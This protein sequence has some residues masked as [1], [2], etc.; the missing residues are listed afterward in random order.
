MCM[1]R[2]MDAVDEHGASGTECFAPECAGI[3]HYNYLKHVPQVYYS[4]D[5][6]QQ[7]KN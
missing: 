6:Q 4:L 1:F 7:K 5:S 3:A 2:V